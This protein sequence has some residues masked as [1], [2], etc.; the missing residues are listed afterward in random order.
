M[1][2]ARR[3]AP[4]VAEVPARVVAFA[5]RPAAQA[6]VRAGLPRRHVRVTVTRTVSAF[7]ASFGAGLVDAAIVDLDTTDEHVEHAVQLARDFPSVGFLGIT[8]FRAGD[9]SHIALCAH[10]DFAD[11]L[12]ERIDGG[13]LPHAVATNGF[14]SRFAATFA[15]APPTLNLETPLQSAVWRCLV[16]RAGRPVRTQEIAQALG[17]TRE[18]LSRTVSA[19]RAPTLK[20]VIDLVRLLAAAELAK[21]PGYD[22]GDV[23][24][25][26]GF[27]SSSHLS[28]TAQRVLGT[29]ASSLASLRGVDVIARFRE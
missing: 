25:V 27:A 17:L 1:L 13:A 2:S 3:P 5:P 9:A 8:G 4:R 10:V 18:H 21:N 6:M 23:A 15:E 12:A 29:K 7:R 16:A 24:R 26:L 19:G 28:T 11:V 14:S 20:R 22:V